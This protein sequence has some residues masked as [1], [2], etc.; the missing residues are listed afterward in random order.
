MSYPIVATPAIVFRSK[1]EPVVP[2]RSFLAGRLAQRV[3][4]R[5]F[6]AARFKQRLL[7]MPSEPVVLRRCFARHIFFRST[8]E[9]AF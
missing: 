4:S 9:P 3:L 8:F 5:S 6:R 7:N 2:S 1:F